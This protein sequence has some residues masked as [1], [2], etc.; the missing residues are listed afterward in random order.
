MQK[1]KN[2]KKNIILKP[3]KKKLNIVIKNNEDNNNEKEIKYSLT[4]NDYKIDTILINNEIENTK[5][6]EI[7][8]IKDKSIYDIFDKKEKNNNFVLNNVEKT[9]FHHL[10]ISFFI[11]LHILS[12][13]KYEILYFS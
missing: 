3:L 11:H 1:K 10:G 6:K 12:I 2:N 9:K 8:M 13:V 5:E 7:Q 4:E